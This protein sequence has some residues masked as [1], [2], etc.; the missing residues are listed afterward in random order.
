MGAP[1]T[2]ALQASG[3][4]AQKRLLALLHGRV[5]TAVTHPAVGWTLFSA[6]PFALYFSPLYSYSLTHPAVHELIHLH[7][8]AVGS[9]FF[10]PVLG[11]DPGR[12]RLPYGGRLL[13]LL[14]MVPVHAFLGIALLGAT[15]LFA[16]HTLSDQH[17]GGGIM[18]AV[19]ELLTLAAAA[20]VLSQWMRA[21]EREAA[22]LDRI[23]GDPVA[24][25]S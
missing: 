20:I 21:D 10:W 5:V 6:S 3:R 19:G 7:F 24:G 23:A 14:V 2:L 12:W 11:V 1:L 8:L 13:Y 25:Y 18:W 4:A 16:A 17:A 15:P 22:R 9:L